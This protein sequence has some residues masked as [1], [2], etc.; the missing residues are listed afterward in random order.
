MPVLPQVV[1]DNQT[2]AYCPICRNQGSPSVIAMRDNVNC[3]CLMGHSLPHAAFWGMNPDK[4]KMETRFAPGQDD[5]KVEVWVNREVLARSQES[6]GQRFH[7]TIASIIRCC[8]AGVP[9]IIDGQQAEKLRKLGIKNGAEMIATA[10]LNIELSGQLEA[11]VAKV[12][13]WE[14]RFKSAMASV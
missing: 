10:E 4:M 8:M 2:G 6:L 9:V 11:A 7:P 5:V 3:F 12:N 14:D 13:E 1:G